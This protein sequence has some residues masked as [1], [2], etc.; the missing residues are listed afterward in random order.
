MSLPLEEDLNRT[1]YKGSQRAPGTYLTTRLVTHAGVPVAFAIRQGQARVAKKTAVQSK[2]DDQ[3]KT[4]VQSNTTTVQSNTTVVQPKT[5]AQLKKDVQPKTDV[6]SVTP[7]SKASNDMQ[8]VPIFEYVVL[9][10][11]ASSSADDKPPAGKSVGGKTRAGDR[12]DAQGW[13]ADPIL[14]PFPNE[15]RIVGQEAVPTYIV[16]TLDNSGSPTDSAGF[17]LDD[18]VDQWMSSTQCLTYMPR[19]ENGN[20]DVKD[21]H[22]EVLSDGEYIY[23]FRAGQ[24]T[25]TKCANGQVQSSDL[26]G[27]LNGHLLCDR[28]VLN[29]GRLDRVVESRFRRSGQRALP[30]NDKDTLGARSIDNVPFYEPTLVLQFAGKLTHARFSVVSNPTTA[31]DTRKWLFVL[32]Q[33]DETQVDVVTV[34]A[35]ASG[36]FDLHGKRFY[37]CK[38]DHPRIFDSQPGVCTAAVG[39]AGA[40]CGKNKKL[41]ITQKRVSERAISTTARNGLQLTKPIDLE[42]F[43]AGFCFEAWVCLGDEPSVVSNTS[44]TNVIKPATTP[45]PAPVK[46]SSA[47]PSIVPAKTTSSQTPVTAPAVAPAKA[48]STAPA[49][50]PT[51]AP[52]TAPAKTSSAAPTQTTTASGQTPTTAPTP[53]PTTTPGTGPVTAPATATAKATTTTTAAASA[54]APNSN[55]IAANGTSTNGTAANGTAAKSTATIASAVNGTAGSGIVPA[56]PSSQDLLVAGEAPTPTRLFIDADLCLCLHVKGTQVARIAVPLQR[57]TWHHVALSRRKGKVVGSWQYTVVLDGE[58]E[59]SSPEAIDTGGKISHIAPGFIGQLDEVRLWRTGLSAAAIKARCG[60]RLVQASMLEACWHLDEG[61]GTFAYDSGS[62]ANHLKLLGSCTWSVSKAPLLP[63]TGLNRRTI[64]LGGGMKVAGGLSVCRY[65]EQISINKAGDSKAAKDDGKKQKRTMRI[66][67]VMLITANKDNKLATFDVVLLD[68]GSLCDWPGLISL[69]PDPAPA[70]N[71]TST[72]ALPAA[73]C[74]ST[75]AEGHPVFFG[76]HDAGR[77]SCDDNPTAIFDSAVGTL[78][79]YYRSKIQGLSAVMYSTSRSLTFHDIGN[80]RVLPRL[81]T[82]ESYVISIADNPSD[83][84]VINVQVTANTI[85]GTKVVEGWRALPTATRDIINI[86]NGEQKE[87]ISLGRIKAFKGDLVDKKN[88]HVTVVL[89]EPLKVSIRACASLVSDD[90]FVTAVDAVSSGQSEIKVWWPP[91]HS[92]TS[93]KDGKA[94]LLEAEADIACLYYDQE[95]LFA[96]S[97]IEEDDTKQGSALISLSRTPPASSPEKPLDK[98]DPTFMDKLLDEP[99]KT[100]TIPVTFSG[101]KSVPTLSSPRRSTAL[102]MTGT[103]ALT[104]M[105]SVLP[106]EPTKALTVETWLRCDKIAKSSTVLAYRCDKASE[107]TSVVAV[108]NQVE[109]DKERYKLVCNINSHLLAVSHSSFQLKRWNHVALMHQKA[110]DLQFDGSN[111]VTLGTAQDLTSPSY[112]ITLSLSIDEKQ[113]GEVTVLQHGHAIRIFLVDGKPVISFDC[114]NGERPATMKTVTIDLALQPKTAYKLAFRRKHFEEF[115]SNQ[116]KSVKVLLLGAC[117]YESGQTKPIRENWGLQEF[118]VRALLGPSDDLKKVPPRGSVKTYVDLVNYLRGDPWTN[119][120]GGAENCSPISAEEHA[121]MWLGGTPSTKDASS[122]FKGTIGH[123]K[124]YSSA[125]E[126][127]DLQALARGAGEDKSLISAWYFDEQETKST[128]AFDDKKRNDAKLVGRPKRVPARFVSD[129]LLRCLVNG[130][131]AKGEELPATGENIRLLQPVGPF[132]ITLGNHLQGNGNLRY[133]AQENYYTGQLDELRIWDEV[134]TRAAIVDNMNTSLSDQ[135]SSLKAYYS[136]DDEEDDKL[137]V[138]DASATCSHLS[139]LRTVAIARC[140]SSAPVGKDAPCVRQALDP[141]IGDAKGAFIYSSPTVCEYAGMDTTSLGELRGS[142]KR[143]YAFIDEA[144]HAWNLVTGFKIGATDLKWMSQV[145]TAPSLIGFIEGAPP[146]PA[147]NYQDPEGE[148]PSSSIVFSR[149]STV[150]HE[151]AYSD[152]DSNGVSVET[153]Y[154]MGAAWDVS[155][156]LAVQTKLTKGKVG[157][158]VK[159][160]VESTGSDLRSFEREET[161]TRTH[162]TSMALTGSFDKAEKRFKPNNVGIA[163]VESSVADLFALR[164]ILGGGQTGPVVSYQLQPNQDIPRDRNLVVFN[165][166]PNYSK[167]GCLDGKYGL[168]ADETNYPNATAG[169][170]NDLSFYKP[171][172]AY[173]IRTKIERDEAQREGS[174]QQ[175]KLN[176]IWKAGGKVPV[177]AQ[178][179]ST[180]RNLCN[181]YVWTA[182]GGTYT[183]AHTTM[184]SFTEEIGLD[185]SRNVD[186]G[187]STEGE[188]EGPAFYMKGTTDYLYKS[189]VKVTQKKSKTS[190]EGFELKTELPGPCNIRDSEHAKI[191]GRVDAYRWMSFLLQPNNDNVQ[192]FFN[193]VVDDAWLQSNDADAAVLRRLK[194]NPDMVSKTQAWR[195]MHRCTYVSRIPE[196]ITAAAVVS[197]DA[198]PAKKKAAGFDA[199]ANWE[200]VASLEPLLRGCKSR[201]EVFQVVNDNVKTLL[202]ALYKSSKYSQIISPLVTYMASVVGAE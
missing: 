111:Y 199:S 12:L 33:K 80:L 173:R 169:S 117:L 190:S 142:Y 120:D 123:V 189:S 82:A 126:K 154:G 153:S 114:Q 180:R 196:K 177:N 174:H 129:S 11:S 18:K 188:T 49:E 56:S 30:A 55:G 57:K 122:G 26:D 91:Y 166:N 92:P 121:S 16:P 115:D 39:K 171:V 194:A 110:T 131:E 168:E 7:D 8:K 152:E 20:L 160:S 155:A 185:Y 68:D 19:G 112:T 101:E 138:K 74:I 157:A 104:S 96:V 172:E 192:A 54:K 46:T 2:T 73:A 128:V 125:L 38:N 24:G 133:L 35:S 64:R 90:I 43:A 27:L 161:T 143:A 195:V 63:P 124:I 32:G 144:S 76:L 53:K 170:S 176:S 151:Y 130:S 136:F 14:V 119:W 9:Q 150:T 78:S 59:A 184:D 148:A 156:G 1:T 147:E 118:D 200:I 164:L 69:I 178:K 159:A 81:R 3:L 28:F 31:P 186:A 72:V 37:E 116:K 61:S 105:K 71:K 88:H 99:V 58:E 127:L 84:R 13:S 187:V 15:V 98:D 149:A 85:N 97:G 182:D 42:T 158:S 4:A 65:S 193:S 22:F 62:N 44:S 94:P 181:S 34:D 17:P 29:E 52:A 45:S 48:P 10:P 132:Q 165:I 95:H 21:F 107:G 66:L 141:D 167:Q 163:L 183:E 197:V 179:T 139:A 79:I 47:T 109:V 23:L 145:Q 67:L 51:T 198:S 106:T 36:L 5:D 102:Q 134:R 41:V 83:K 103:Y 86:V 201:Q 87:Q 113:G 75:S 100:A 140:A 60:L 191:A 25:E 89:A 175:L 40:T 137:V 108:V 6:Q 146:V 202:P 93:G 70:A 135:P 77:L 162:D 50:A